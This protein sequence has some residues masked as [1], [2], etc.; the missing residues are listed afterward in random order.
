MKIPPTDPLRLT[1]WKCVYEMLK[2]ALMRGEEDLVE[3]LYETEARV[4]DL[5]REGD[6][7]HVVY[8]KSKNNEVDVLEADLVIGADGA[9]S[10]VRKIVSKDNVQPQ[11]AGYVSWRGR[12]PER[13]VS[14]ET[15][16][17]LQN[18][19]VIM[20]VGGGYMIS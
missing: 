18:R 9:H 10:F 19:C 3:A 8:R 7:M 14:P 11:Y 13:D 4:E 6:K 15:R 5:R 17:V 1:T 12:V 20:R 16:E 2:G